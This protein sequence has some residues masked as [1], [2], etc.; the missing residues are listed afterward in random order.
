MGLYAAFIMGGQ[1]ETITADIG[2]EGSVPGLAFGFSHLEIAG[3]LHSLSTEALVEYWY[4]L[5]IWDTIFPLVY[6]TMYISWISFL[7]K[8]TRIRTSGLSGI[9]LFPLLPMLA[10][11]TENFY[12]FR[13][14]QE[15]V[16]QKTV[17][18]SWV[19]IASIVNQ[20]KW[21]LSSINYLIIITAIVLYFIQ[22]IHKRKRSF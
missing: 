21:I 7:L 2:P 10:D 20:T 9:N 15:F 16:I 14:L 19:E 5:R 6:G 11:F 4:M 13:V 17:N 1:T 3:F 12:E 8:K 22:L 18:A